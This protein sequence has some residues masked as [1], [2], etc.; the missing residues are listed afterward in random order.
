M[1]YKDKTLPGWLA[2]ALI[3]AFY[4]FAPCSMWAQAKPPIGDW[5]KPEDGVF[6]LEEAPRSCPH[7]TT[8]SN[9]A[10]AGPLLYF[11]FPELAVSSMRAF[12]AAQ[13]ENG[14]CP[15]AGPLGGPG[16]PHGLRIPGGHERG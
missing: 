5:C 15:A 6:A 7:V 10:M 4:Y 13:K 16:K 12:R 1:I 3:N 2:D 14:E 9:L 11:F 8:L